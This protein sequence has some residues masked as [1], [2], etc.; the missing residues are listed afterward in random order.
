MVAGIGQGQAPAYSEGGRGADEILCNCLP[1]QPDY[2]LCPLPHPRIP[3]KFY[4]NV[5]DNGEMAAS[6]Q[7]V[8]WVR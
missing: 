1:C 2:G 8:T 3:V 7:L 5:H 6:D 4:D